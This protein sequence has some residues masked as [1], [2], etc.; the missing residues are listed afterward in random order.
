MEFMGRMKACDPGGH[1]RQF[2]VYRSSD[3]YRVHLDGA[4]I[5]RTETHLDALQAIAGEAA[6]RQLSRSR[7]C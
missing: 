3:G 7:H 6:A 4:E 1:I 2:D 5:R